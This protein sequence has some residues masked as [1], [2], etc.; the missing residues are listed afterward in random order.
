MCTGG[1]LQR[2]TSLGHD[3]D[4]ANLAGEISQGLVFET[5]LAHFF[6]DQRTSLFSEDQR[7]TRDK[8]S[9]EIARAANDSIN[10]RERRS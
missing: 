7:E 3:F 5:K 4:Q 8:L 10:Q 6:C 2:H 9:A 1:E